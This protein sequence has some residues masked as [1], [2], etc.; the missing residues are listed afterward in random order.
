MDTNTVQVIEKFGDKLDTYI[1]AF[2]AKAGVAT[3]HFWPIFVKQQ[4][5]EGWVN[6]IHSLI[7]LLV[8]LFCVTVIIKNAKIVEENGTAVAKTVICA[9]IGVMFLF[10]FL[11]SISEAY[12]GIGQIFNPEYS[13]VRA[14]TSMVK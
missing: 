10:G 5:I 2:A 8:F 14:L 12:A 11:F 4:V 1:A 7:L 9:I 6:C 13:A 3:D